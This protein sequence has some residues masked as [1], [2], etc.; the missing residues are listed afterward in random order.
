[1]KKNE[2]GATVLYVS[3]D[4]ALKVFRHKLV[5]VENHVSK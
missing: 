3:H 4:M 5:E 2:D 1:M